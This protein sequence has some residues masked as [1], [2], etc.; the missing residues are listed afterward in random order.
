MFFLS[1]FKVSNNGDK[2][3]LYVGV[4]SSSGYIR[5]MKRTSGSTNDYL[6]FYSTYGINSKIGSKEHFV[7]EIDEN[8][9][10]IYFYS[11]GKG[12]RKVLEKKM[13]VNG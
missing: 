4:S 3:T 13:M 10:E 2:V 5:K 1:D 12:Y 8:A 7:L 6:T 11:G 9:D